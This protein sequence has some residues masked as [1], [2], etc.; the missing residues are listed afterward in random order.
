MQDEDDAP[1]H[2]RSSL[3]RSRSARVSAVFF[4]RASGSASVD[5]FDCESRG[6]SAARESCEEDSSSSSCDAAPR[7][8]RTSRLN[9]L[10]EGVWI[11]RSRA[12]VHVATLLALSPT[13]VYTACGLRTRVHF[14]SASYALLALMVA[15]VVL[16]ALRHALPSN[17]Q[18]HLKHRWVSVCVAVHAV[19]IAFVTL[20]SAL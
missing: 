17:L 15:L 8:R 19:C 7:C 1:R 6:D 9:A 2:H 14:I 12:R 13:F 5:D 11:A 4:G 10:S 20:V 3:S 16:H 18:R